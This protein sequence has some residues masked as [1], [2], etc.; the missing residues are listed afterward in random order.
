MKLSTAIIVSI[1]AHVGVVVLLVLNFQFSKVEVKQSSA[2][3]PQINAKAV[4]SKR[5]E[6]LVEKLK[7]EKLSQKKQEQDRLDKLKQAEEDAKRK[8]REEEKKAAD[9]RKRHKKA[10]E[11]RLSEERKAEDLRKKRIKDEQIRKKRIEKEKKEKAEAERKRKVAA[12]AERKRKA[13][14]EAERKRKAKEEAERQRKAAEE[15]ARQ[16]ALERE[17]QQQMDAEAAELEAAR[18]KY[19]LSEVD[20]FHNRISNKIKRNWFKPEK[21]GHCIFRINIS[22]GGLVLNITV[23]EGDTAYCDTGRRAIRKAEPLPVSKDPDVFE[24]LKTTTFS[25]DHEGNNESL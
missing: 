24:E 23:L 6:Q 17:M 3:T 19:V 15:K 12:E 18:N 10:E 13:K 20:I 1:I 2:T 11:K 22:P 14:E 4:N 9:A 16:E 5:V 8:R 21:V 7:Q 25:L